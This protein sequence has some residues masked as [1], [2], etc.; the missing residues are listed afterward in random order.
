MSERTAGFDPLRIDF[1]A[2]VVVLAALPLISVGTAAGTDPLWWLG[3][4]ALVV[5]SLTTL[6]TEFVLD[7]GR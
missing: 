3:L 7:G 1:A 4:C 6:A 2:F 5:G